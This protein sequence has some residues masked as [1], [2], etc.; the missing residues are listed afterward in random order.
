MNI[1]D[2]IQE[3][4]AKPEHIRIRYVYGCVA[5][6]MIVIFILWIFSIQVSFHDI[7]DKANQESNAPQEEKQDVTPESSL[8]DWVQKK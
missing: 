8:N 1:Q 6:S 3:I 5:V 2:K 7:T 4:C